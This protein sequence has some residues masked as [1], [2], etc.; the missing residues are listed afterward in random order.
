MQTG[1]IQ[2]NFV[3]YKNI[4]VFKYSVLGSQSHF[5]IVCLG[6]MAKGK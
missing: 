1:N 3:Q 2:L 4:L 6:D 5:S